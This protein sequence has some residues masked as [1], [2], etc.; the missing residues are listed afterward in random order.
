MMGKVMDG[1]LLKATAEA[2]HKAIGSTDP[3]GVT[4]AAD[5]VYEA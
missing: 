2:H 5:A 1:N 3:K 4:F